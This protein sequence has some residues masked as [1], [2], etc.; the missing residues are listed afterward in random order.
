MARK[1]DGVFIVLEGIDGSGTTTH[2]ALYAAWL[3]ERRRV[4]HVTREPSDGPIGSL[5]RLGLIGRLRL[6]AGNQAQTMALLF[7]ADRLDHFAHEIG[8]HLRDSSVVLCD[9]YDLSSIAYQTASADEQLQTEGIEAWVRS[10]NRFAPRPDAT[11]V[12]DVA[13]EEAERRRRGRQ[14]ALELYEHSELQARLAER[15]LTAETLVPGDRVLHVDGNGSVDETAAG[16]RAA[17][18][19][20]VEA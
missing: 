14:Y 17:L 15:Y 4:V 13:P 8:P 10:L 6:G 5:L 18:G 1:Y 12:L 2:A 19:P 3:R 7:A 11:V 9:R 16:I 20:I